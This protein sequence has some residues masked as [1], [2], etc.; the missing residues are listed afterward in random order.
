MVYAPILIPTLC[1]DRHFINAI[2]SLKKN[3]WAQYTDV[4]IAVDYPK[5]EKHRNGYEKICAYL[6][7]GDF[8]CFKSFHVVKRD[9]NYGAGTNLRE[10]RES[11]M[12]MYDR[13]IMAEDDIVF[14]PAFLEY[15]DKCLMAFENDE[16]VLAINGYSYPVP[17]V[18]AEGATVIK[19]SATYSAWGTGH[20]RE[21]Y[22][23]ARERLTNGYLF[24]E[25]E[26]AKK[27]GALDKLIRGRYY[28]YMEYAL[29][30][31]S[32]RYFRGVSDMSMGI[33]MNLENMVVITPV[34]TKTI[35]TGFDGSGVNC[36]KVKASGKIHSQAYDYAN[37]PIDQAGSFDVVVDT[38]EHVAV[39]REL[40]DDFLHVMHEQK[41]RVW[42]FRILSWVIGRNGSVW[43]Y[44]TLKGMKD[45][46]RR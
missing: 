13:W 26:R 37:Q 15:M 24:D 46:L 45:K 23:Q 31:R 21:K 9:R 30:K 34:I 36:G 33:Y 32:E 18:L 29:T 1:R 38:K 35:N 2:E 44:Q 11:I 40:L 17:Y 10:L 25:F 16:E 3:T 39:N 5:V 43:L 27:S 4:Y 8:S 22:L 42:I 12:R 20:W 28:D 7:A 14:S 19:Q 41:V 6:E